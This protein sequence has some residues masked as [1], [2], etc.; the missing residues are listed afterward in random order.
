V[1]WGKI[2]RVLC[3]RGCKYEFGQGESL[4]DQVSSNEQSAINRRPKAPNAEFKP[5]KEEQDRDQPSAENAS[6]PPPLYP[7]SIWPF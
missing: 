4:H 6:Y 3:G 7:G 1:V 2:M 5:D